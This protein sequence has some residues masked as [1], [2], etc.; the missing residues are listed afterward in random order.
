[1]SIYLDGVENYDKVKLPRNK[2]AGTTIAFEKRITGELVVVEQ[3]RTKSNEFAF[4]TMRIE[5]TGKGR[6]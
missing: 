1:M 5:E 3:L 6:K 4:H 2:G